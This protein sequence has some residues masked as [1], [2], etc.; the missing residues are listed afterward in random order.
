MVRQLRVATEN[1]RLRVDFISMNRGGAV[2][3]DRD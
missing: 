3:I 1:K 2:V